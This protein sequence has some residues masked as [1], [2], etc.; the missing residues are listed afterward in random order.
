MART[1]DVVMPSIKDIFPDKWLRADVINGH[2]PR[3]IIEAITVEQLYNPRSKKHEPKL[4]VKFHKKE[5][6][7]VCNKTQAQALA[8][9]CKTDDY[10][11]W[12][13]HEVV[14][15]TGK[16]PNGADTILISPVPDGAPTA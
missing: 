7:L 15:S 16:A 13:G 3:V 8:T 5:L 9:I 11:R 1:G 12:H 6:R 14:L 4:V 2:R 10:T